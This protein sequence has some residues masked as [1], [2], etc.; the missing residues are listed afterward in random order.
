MSEHLWGPGVGNSY[1]TVGALL[2]GNSWTTVGSNES[3]WLVMGQ[4]V[5]T[6]ACDGTIITSS[7]LSSR[8]STIAMTMALESTPATSTYRRGGKRRERERECDQGR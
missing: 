4:G 8:R 5:L 6:M 1:T 3:G 7:E 2:V